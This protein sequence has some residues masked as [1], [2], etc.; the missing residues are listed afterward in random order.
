MS[1]P[2][3]IVMKLDP[4]GTRIREHYPSRVKLGFKMHVFNPI[5]YQTKISAFYY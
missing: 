1:H 5:L 3:Q 4:R 2:R